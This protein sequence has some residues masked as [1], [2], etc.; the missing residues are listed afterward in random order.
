MKRR[1]LLYPL[2]LSL[3]LLVSCGKLDQSYGVSLKDNKA[4]HLQ[5][6]SFIE[7]EKA[8]KNIWENKI[9]IIIRGVTVTVK[10]LYAGI[11][12]RTIA[13]EK[14]LVDKLNLMTSEINYEI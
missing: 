6:I 9:K 11:E 1:M 2:Q 8:N 12:E 14:V 7:N 4:V 10:D 5:K 13:G 3:V